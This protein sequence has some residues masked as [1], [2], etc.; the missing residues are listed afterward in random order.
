MANEYSRQ[1]KSQSRMSAA[2]NAKEDL[3]AP[4]KDLSQFSP[5]SNALLPERD[6]SDV[7]LGR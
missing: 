1:G 3:G 6:F 2:E 5:L 7:I 4:R